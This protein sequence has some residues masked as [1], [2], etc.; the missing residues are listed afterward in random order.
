ME[1]SLNAVKSLKRAI[2]LVTGIV[3]VAIISGA[4]YYALRLAS[5]GAAYKVKTLCS[6]VFVANREPASMLNIDLA[7]DDLS[8]LRLIDTKVDYA[9]KQ[10]TADFLGIIKRK[11]IYR[12]GL[13]CFLAYDLVRELSGDKAATAI[14]VSPI[15][16]E[17]YDHKFNTALDWAFSEPDSTRLRRTRA[18][19]ILHNGKI[20]AERY[21]PGFSKDTPL[22]GWSMTKGVINA[23]VGIMVREGKLHLNEPVPVPEWQEPDDP[24]RR[25]TLDHLLHMTSGLRFNEDYGNPLEDVTYMLLGVPDMGAYAS[26]KSLEVEPGTKWSYSSGTTN[27]ISRIIRQVVGDTNY[28]NFPRGALF[29]RIGMNSAII[30]QDASGT[31]VGS[32]FMYATA[33]DWAKFGQ[34]YLQDGIWGGQRILPEGWVKFTTT[35]APKIPDKEYGAHFWLKLPKEFRSADPA[36]FV[37]ADAFH[38]VGLEGQFVSIIP[39]RRLVVVRLGLTRYP[40]AWQQDRFLNLVLDA[41]EPSSLSVE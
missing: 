20:V 41:V 40:S 3:A 15:M 10:V 16:P 4:S 30:E 5:I 9:S 24:R 37:P 27:I 33:R 8:I 28:R 32:S 6:G 7:A 2:P 17:E 25:I 34:L 14:A 36:E 39:S 38:A 21:A 35:P 1:H 11:A 12:P 18:V 31:F 26:R 23:L 19:V 13:G 22:L 29:Q